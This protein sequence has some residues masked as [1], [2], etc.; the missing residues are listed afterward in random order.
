MEL[1]LIFLSGLLGTARTYLEYCAI[2][3]MPSVLI[4]EPWGI[5]KGLEF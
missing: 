4:N 3:A 5:E 2:H 1:G